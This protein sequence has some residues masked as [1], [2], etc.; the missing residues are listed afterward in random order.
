[1]SQGLYLSDPGSPSRLA[2]ATGWLVDASVGS[3]AGVVAVIAVAG[4]GMLLLTGR[5]AVRRGAFVILG[6]FLVFGARAVA[7]GLTG[8]AGSRSGESRSV[9]DPSPLPTTAASPK[10]YDPYGGASLVQ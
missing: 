3:V 6:C 7:T 2:A 10:P 4:I 8:G 9:P 1:M 5:L